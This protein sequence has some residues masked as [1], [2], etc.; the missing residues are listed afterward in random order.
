MKPYVLGIDPG[1]YGAMALYSPHKKSIQFLEDMPLKMRERTNHCERV[2]LDCEKV[3]QLLAPYRD[4]TEM[5][6]IEE[7]SA[8]PGQGVTSM[9]RFGRSTGQIEGIL[10]A[11]GFPI[12]HITPKSWKRKMNLSSDK[13]HSLELATRLF[14]ALKENFLR[15]KDNGRAEAALLAVYGSLFGGRSS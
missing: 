7:V 6:F 9:F 14:P 13:T 15:K 11:L 12:F 2:V 5:A 4:E 1:F 10:T 3:V 8:R